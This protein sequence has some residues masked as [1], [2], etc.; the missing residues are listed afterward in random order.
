MQRTPI[1][2]RSS[3]QNEWETD[4][5]AGSWMFPVQQPLE[6]K[7]N[8]QIHMRSCMLVLP[9]P[10]LKNPVFLA[11]DQTEWTERNQTSS[12]TEGAV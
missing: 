9:N 4:M 10:G 2:L 5:E 1:W 11:T 12:Q 8:D 3:E 7:S 6:E